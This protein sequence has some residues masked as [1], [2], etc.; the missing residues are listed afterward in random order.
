MR[1]ETGD[2]QK[3]AIR[4]YERA[5]FIRCA[6]FG[7]YAAMPREAVA[8]SVFFEKRVA[9]HPSRSTSAGISG[10]SAGGIG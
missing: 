5:G 2:K 7:A 1:L 4:L 9:P 10:P 8:T 6:V 3:A